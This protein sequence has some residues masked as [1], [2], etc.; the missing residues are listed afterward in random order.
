MLTNGLMVVYV[1]NMYVIIV[2][3]LAENGLKRIDDLIIIDI[4][5][6]ALNYSH[7]YFILPP[8]T[9]VV[10]KQKESIIKPKKG[11]AQIEI[12]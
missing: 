3:K 8:M 2:T 6:K 10:L 9:Q 1:K 7:V 12:K 11:E 4:P 5:A